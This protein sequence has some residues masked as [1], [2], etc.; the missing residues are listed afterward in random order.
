MK[1]QLTLSR[2]LTMCILCSVVLFS[3]CGNDDS[4]DTADRDS[5]VGEY[6][7]IETCLSIDDD[8][9]ITIIAGDADNEVLIAN[10]YASGITGLKATVDGND[11]T[12][13]SQET[14]NFFGIMQTFSGTGSISGEVLTITYEVVTPDIDGTE[15]PDDTCT[16][17]FTKR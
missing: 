10:L 2:I 9:D 4:G 14:T 15:I 5:I 1:F 16:T 8:Y 13:A 17:I 6:D 3:S 12:I 7:G 11:I